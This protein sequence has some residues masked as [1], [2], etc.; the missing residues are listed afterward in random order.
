M[1]VNTLSLTRGDTAALVAAVNG[2]ISDAVAGVDEP[3]L[4]QVVEYAMD[5]GKRVRPLLTL[6]TCAASGGDPFDALDGAVACELLHTASLLHDDIMDRAELRRG[7]RT[8]HTLYDTPTAILAGDAMI[9]L[10]FRHVY[11]LPMPVRDPALRLFIEG[12]VALCEGQSHDLQ[13]VA[14][15][16]HASMVEKKTARLLEVCTG[17]GGIVAGAEPTVVLR[18]RVFGRNL[19]MAFQ[20]AD[21]LLDVTGTEESTGK[22]VAMDARNGRTTYLTAVHAAADPLARVR[23]AIAGYTDAASRA[24]ESLP[25]S[26]ARE[27]LLRMADGLL[28]RSS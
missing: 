19:G 23:A 7:R 21:D 24:V 11:R 5:G 17:L 3:H 12:F 13:G 16:Q 15:R 10:A 2:R 6:I 14:A 9:A 22:S 18:L 8:V 28:G 20:A 26:D 25:P 27:S 4:R 1:D